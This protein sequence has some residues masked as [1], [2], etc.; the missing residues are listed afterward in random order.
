[1][2]ICLIFYQLLPTNSVGNEEEQQMRVQILI[3]GCKGLEGIKRRR[4]GDILISGSFSGIV[5]FIVLFG[6][7]HCCRLDSKLHSQFCSIIHPFVFS[8]AV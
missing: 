7:I 1:M 5:K 8:S 2:I 4:G 3:S 6:L